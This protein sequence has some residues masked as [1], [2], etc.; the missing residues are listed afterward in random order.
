MASDLHR[1]LRSSHLSCVGGTSA[2]WS[3]LRHGRH[4]MTKLRQAH[5]ISEGRLAASMTKKTL[6]SGYTHSVHGMQ[7][8]SCFRLQAPQH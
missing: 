8:L 2:C 5:W 3:L 7:A 4:W 1:A 6:K